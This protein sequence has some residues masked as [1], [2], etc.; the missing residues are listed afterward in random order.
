[1]VPVPSPVQ[2]EYR[3]DA[4]DGSWT[5]SCADPHQERRL[6]PWRWAERRRLFQAASRDGYFDGARFV[7][8]VA[9]TLYDPP[10]PPELSR[11][12]RTRPRPAWAWPRLGATPSAAAKCS[13]PTGRLAS[14]HIGEQP[15]AALDGCRR[16]S[17]R[18]RRRMRNGQHQNRGPGRWLISSPNRPGCARRSPAVAPCGGLGRSRCRASR[19]RQGRTERASGVGPSSGAGDR[20][21]DALSTSDAARND[22]AT[23][24]SRI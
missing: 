13:S 6:R 9:G 4:A 12:M 3:E 10:P 5:I 8:G 17:R 20:L 21:P 1:M 19:I 14:N 22:R 2:G 18:P 7:A 11:S 15:A 24:R 16:A 23:D